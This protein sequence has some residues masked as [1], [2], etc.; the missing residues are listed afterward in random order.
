M[1]NKPSHN[2]TDQSGNTYWF[3]TGHRN[4]LADVDDELRDNPVIDVFGNRR[5][6]KDDMLHRLDG[7]ACEYANGDQY[8]YKYGKRHRLDGPAMAYSRTGKQWFIEGVEHTEEQVR[9]LAFVNSIPYI[10]EP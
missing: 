9:M 1:P 2:P 10:N 3:E 4:R 5:W 8:W 6:H 7:P